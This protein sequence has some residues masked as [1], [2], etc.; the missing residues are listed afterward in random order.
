MRTWPSTRRSGTLYLQRFVVYGFEESGMPYVL[1]PTSYVIS[2]RDTKGRIQLEAS[3]VDVPDTKA[4]LYVYKR[5][6]DVS[7][8]PRRKM[9]SSIKNARAAA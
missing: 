9:L 6:K 7:F 2:M 1:H 8:L 3:M 4:Y 5:P